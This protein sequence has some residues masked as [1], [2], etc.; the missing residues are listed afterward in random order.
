MPSLT[1]PRLACHAFPDPAAPRLAAPPCIFWKCDQVGAAHFSATPF[2]LICLVYMLTYNHVTQCSH[3][4]SE[5]N[6]FYSTIESVP[7]LLEAIQQQQE[8]SPLQRK[9]ALK[10]SLRP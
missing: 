1:S 7:A 10:S 9:M 8:G 4:S 2:P 6:Y 3:P 5:S